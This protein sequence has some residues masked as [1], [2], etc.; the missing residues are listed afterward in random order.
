M[1]WNSM[2]T[3]TGRK[4]INS[5]YFLLILS[6]VAAIDHWWPLTVIAVLAWIG[7]LIPAGIWF[8]RRPSFQLLRRRRPSENRPFGSPSRPAVKRDDSDSDSR[9]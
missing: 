3:I 6:C 7:W 9:P 4:L 5:G 8:S 1:R 2:F